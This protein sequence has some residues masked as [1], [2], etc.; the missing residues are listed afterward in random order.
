MSNKSILAL[1]VVCL[2]IGS[3][4]GGT[5]SGGTG[6]PE[7]PYR[8]AAPQDIV[9]LSSTPYDWDGIFVVVNDI[10]MKGFS[11]TQPIGRIDWEYPEYSQS[12]RG[13]FFGA[14]HKIRNFTWTSDGVDCVG[15]FGYVQ[16]GEI[17][18]LG[19]ENVNV[20]AAS[21]SEGC[22]GG[23]VGINEGF[24]FGCYLT[25]SVSG[26]E[27]GEIGGLVG[28]NFSQNLEM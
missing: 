18:S 12:F 2:W 27:Q 4:A 22:V 9:E 13:E 19:L 14:G 10:D 24:I 21:S 8:I 15:L 1:I 5:Y 28:V 16:S 7:D 11:L 17:Q 26:P 23:L 3:A 20:N 6:T 25:G